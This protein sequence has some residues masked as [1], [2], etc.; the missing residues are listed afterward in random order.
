[1][2]VMKGFSEGDRATLEAV[3]SALRELRS[4]FALYEADIHQWVGDQLAMSGLDFGHEVSIGRGCRIDFLIGHIGVEI[5]KGKPDAAAVLT[6]LRR[7]A[8]CS[9]VHGLVIL[10]QRTI[11]LPDRVGDVPVRQIALSQLWGI[12]L[13]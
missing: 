5:K 3:L 7:Y 4:P 8:A 1:M 13:P 6:Q 9:D 2:S 12:A 11:R 10:S